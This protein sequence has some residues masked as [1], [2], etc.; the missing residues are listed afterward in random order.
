M[1]QPKAVKPDQGVTEAQKIIKE[2]AKNLDYD[3]VRRR[4]VYSILP[5]IIGLIVVALLTQV[6]FGK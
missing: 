3:N 5:I 2:T 4:D 1:T 6:M